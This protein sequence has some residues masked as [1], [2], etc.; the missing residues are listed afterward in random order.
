[1]CMATAY[2][3]R[4]PRKEVLLQEVAYIQLTEDSMVLKPLFGEQKRV[5]ASIREID[6][7]NSTILFEE[8]EEA[9]K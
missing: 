1:M 2:M 8:M 7:L 5:K 4:G 9:G 3:K 6:F